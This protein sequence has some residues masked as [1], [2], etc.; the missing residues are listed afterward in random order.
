MSA[1]S[2]REKKLRDAVIEAVMGF[3]SSASY[4]PAVFAAALA[5]LIACVRAEARVDELRPLRAMGLI[6]QKRLDDAE[7]ELAAI[8]E[9]K[10]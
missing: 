4:E 8:E 7:A 1:M 10:P 9:G 6:T 2:E 3:I 5:A